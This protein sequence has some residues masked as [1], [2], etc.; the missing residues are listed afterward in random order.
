[1]FYTYYYGNLPIYLRKYAFVCESP[2][3]LLPCVRDRRIPRFVSIMYIPCA[4]N[5]RR[6]IVMYYGNVAPL[7]AVPRNQATVDHAVIGRMLQG[8]NRGLAY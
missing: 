7:D 3:R 1:M 2:S 8:A 5:Y 4:I 6:K